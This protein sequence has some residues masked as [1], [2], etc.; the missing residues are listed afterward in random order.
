MASTMN[1]ILTKE[2]ETAKKFSSETKSKNFTHAPIKT[3]V[4]IDEISNS[5]HNLS[6]FDLEIWKKRE[7]L[8]D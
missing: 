2:I 3:N 8:H 1:L 4:L 5:I 6:N 7:I